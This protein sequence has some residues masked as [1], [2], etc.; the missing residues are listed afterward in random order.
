MLLV[1]HTLKRVVFKPTPDDEPD[2]SKINPILA[3]PPDRM[4][5]SKRLA[6]AYPSSL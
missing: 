2:P 5:E 4:S 3:Q 1:T 6:A